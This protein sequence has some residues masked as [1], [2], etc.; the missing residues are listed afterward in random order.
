MVQTE[1]I[2]SIQPDR[3]PQDSIYV[4]L[5]RF[6]ITD[7]YLL[8]RKR[9]QMDILYPFKFTPVYKEKIW[10]GQK[11]SQI[12]KHN[13]GDLPNCGEVW[14]VSGVNDDPSVVSNGFLAGNEL[15][16]LVEVYMGDLVGEK[17]YDTYGDV[18]PILVK[19]IDSNDWLSVQVHPDDE[20][21]EKMHIGSGKTEMWYV[22]QS[23][24]HAQLISGFNQKI[25]QDTYQK[26]LNNKKLKDILQFVDAK[27]EDVFFIP[28]GKIHA[29]GPGLLI[30]EIQQTSDNTFRVYDWDRVDNKGIGRQL[31][32]AEALQ[33]IDFEN[34]TE[35]KTKYRIK[36]DGSSSLVNC[37]FFTTNLVDLNKPL[38]KDYSEIDSFVILMCVDGSCELRWDGQAMHLALSETVLIPNL[39]DEIELYPKGNCKLLEVYIP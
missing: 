37:E 12:L 35:A 2:G 31:H 29:L 25:D 8:L 27:K 6:A 34:E 26:A 28:S 36:P 17:V 16:E 4:V 5:C 10:G 32:T 3:S 39:I 1:G 19:V 20:L 23:D 30:A 13:V 38:R 9:A 15:N 33:A 18:F 24:D 14:L 11:I 21:A 7:K 22:L